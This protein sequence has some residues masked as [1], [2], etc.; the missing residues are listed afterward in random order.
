MRA[1]LIVVTGTGTGIGKTHVACAALTAAARRGQVFGY[2]PV[3]SGL[4]EPGPTDSERLD[5]C[6]SFHVQHSPGLRLQAPLSP[7]AAA[8][9]EGATLD[10]PAIRYFVGATREGGVAVLVEL[11]GGLFT[12]LAEGFRNVDAVRTLDPTA[13]VLL[14]PNRLGVLHDVGAAL[15]GAA[16]LRATIHGV[17][18]VAPETPDVSTPHNARDLEGAPGPVWLGEW[19]RGS[20]TDLADAP[21]TANL[22]ALWLGPTA[23]PAPG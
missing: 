14:A 2:K 9:M 10:W 11:P 4:S 21:A 15:A 18:L 6:S 1:P 13:V 7:Q 23:E 19:P 5:A 8:K 22:L 17:G 20:V 16:H 3:E 12:P